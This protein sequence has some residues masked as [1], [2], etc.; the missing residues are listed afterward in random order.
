ML[1]WVGEALILYFIKPKTW[2]VVYT[3]VYTWVYIC[4]YIYPPMRKA[5]NYNDKMPL[6]VNICLIFRDVKV[7]KEKVILNQR[8]SVYSGLSGKALLF[9][10]Y[11][12]RDSR[13]SR[14]RDVWLLEEEHLNRGTSRCK[15]PEVET[16]FKC[17][18]LRNSKQAGVDGGDRQGTDWDNHKEFR[19][20]SEWEG[21]SEE[22]LSRGGTWS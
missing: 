19:F 18:C 21:K 5:S 17:S 9:K 22:V 13:D 2:V 7:K 4:P 12:S 20:Y 16:C 11:L 10:W 3:W 1:K 15:V 8:N 14:I 6:I